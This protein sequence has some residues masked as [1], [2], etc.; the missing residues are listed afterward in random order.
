[1]VNFVIKWM[2]ESWFDFHECEEMEKLIQKLIEL[3]SELNMDLAQKLTTA[4]AE[5]TCKCGMG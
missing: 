1:V 2:A 5:Q 4:K 3:I